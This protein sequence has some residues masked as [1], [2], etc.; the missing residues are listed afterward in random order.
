MCNEQF[1]TVN[2]ELENFIRMKLSARNEKD[3]IK[4]TI[5]RRVKWFYDDIF[6]SVSG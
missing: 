1:P 3:G 2:V 4:K 6:L 5:K